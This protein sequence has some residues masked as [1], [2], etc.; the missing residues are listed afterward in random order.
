MY[1]DNQGSISWAENG[2]SKVKHVEL[3]HHFTQH[4]IESGQ[5]KAT[6]VPPEDKFA[7]GLTKDFKK[8]CQGLSVV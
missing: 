1:H 4:L 7:D 2:L 6:Y 5:S 8:I 3:K